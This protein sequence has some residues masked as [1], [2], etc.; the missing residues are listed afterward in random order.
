MGWQGRLGPKVL[1]YNLRTGVV[2][3][4]VPGLRSWKWTSSTRAQRKRAAAAKAKARTAARAAAKDRLERDLYGEIPT[5]AAGAAGTGQRRP[6][7]AAAAPAG[8]AHEGPAP[9]T[10][11]EYNALPPEQRQDRV[12]Q[13]GH[14]G[15]TTQ[16]G[17]HCLNGAGCSIASH[18]RQRGRRPRA[19]A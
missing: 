18:V 15:A 2:V 5:D 14:C 19:R 8:A 11:E 9:I 6:P 17:G 3:L 16:D 4:D 13:A 7:A 1:H 12:R 10:Q